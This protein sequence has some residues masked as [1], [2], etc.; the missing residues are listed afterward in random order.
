MMSIN[1]K[2]TR[3]ISV[4]FFDIFSLIEWDYSTSKIIS[5]EKQWKVHEISKE[6]KIINEKDFD[7]GIRS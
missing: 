2:L 7:I 6:K 4:N 1:N 5:I 3:Q